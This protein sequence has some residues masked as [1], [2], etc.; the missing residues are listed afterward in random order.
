MM[1]YLKQY[2]G[3][4]L[5]YLVIGG[6]A[7]L[8]F[9]SWKEEHDARLLAE[10]QIK[11]SD[12]AVKVSQDQITTLQ[13]QIS[14]NDAKSAQQIAALSKLVTSVKTPAQAAAEIPQV[15]PN[16]PS[17][18]VVEPDNSIAFPKEDVLP[19]FQDLAEGKTCAVKLAQIQAD[20]A[21]EQQIAAQKDVQLG[22]RDKEIAVLK[23][24]RGFWHRLGS[25]MKQVGI[26]IGIGVAIVEVRK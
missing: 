10:Q 9:H 18:V 14:V 5:F 19:L 3:T 2:A 24:P 25:A 15:A 22:A 16:L 13:K 20:Y 21:A 17:P 26:G 12:A 4:H 8:A 1:A 7:L 23:H 6:I 11:A